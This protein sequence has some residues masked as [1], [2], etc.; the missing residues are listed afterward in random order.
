MSFGQLLNKNNKWNDSERDLLLCGSNCEGYV[1]RTHSYTLGK[2]SVINGN[3]YKELIDTLYTGYENPEIPSYSVS[4][5]FIKEDNKKVYFLAQ[6]DEEILLYDFN[7]LLN[8][9]FKIKNIYINEGY[10][11]YLIDS[12]NYQGTKRYTIHLKSMHD[13]LTWID[14]IG[15]KEGF[16]YASHW[17]P[18]DKLLCSYQNNILTYKNEYNTNCIYVFP[19]IIDNTEDL[20]EFPISIYPNPTSNK[21]IID[22]NTIIDKIELLA[23]SGKLLK[24]NQPG[25]NKYELD[26]TS[27]PRGIYIIKVNHSPF[28]IIKN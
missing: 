21:V 23:I 28:K 16:M 11:V 13:T 2:D 10:K 14:G 4:A 7:L 26:L 25:I 22:C 5:G 15:A 8:D 17:D 19:T 12:L 9:S 27:L 18:S 6:Y 3:I 24:M 1:I 20:N